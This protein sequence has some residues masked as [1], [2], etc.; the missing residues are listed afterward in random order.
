MER[1]KIENFRLDLAIDALLI[2]SSISLLIFSIFSIQGNILQLIFSLLA[3]SLL[4]GYA[5][6]TIFGLSAH[7]S[8]LEK[9]VISFVLSYAFTGF[10]TLI[11]LNL[12]E[13]V[14]VI[15]ILSS[16]ILLGL[17]S[18][19]RHRKQKTFQPPKSLAQNIDSLAIIM[20]LIFLA[21]S[22]YIL[23]PGFTLLLGTDAS[24]HYSLSV[25]LNRTPE[26]YI[27]STYLASHLHESMFIALSNSSA[28]AVQSALVSLN[29]MLPLAFYIMAK[30]YLEKIDARL[31]SV[32][33]LFWV[34][35]TNGY[36]GFSW[37]YLAFLKL[38]SIGQSQIQILSVTADKTYNGTIYGILGLW[39]IPGVVSVIAFLVAF[40]LLRKKDIPATKCIL[41]FSII[42]AMLFLTH[43]TEAVI[44]AL[45]IAAY[46]AF[47]KNPR[48]KIDSALKGSLIGF[49]L[50]A[51]IYYF[52]SQFTSRF[53]LTI[54]LLTSI[55]LP[56]VIL[57]CSL[58]I[59]R[60]R[61]KINF[62]IYY[63]KKIV[64][65]SP[66]TFVIILI[67]VYFLGLFSWFSF[68]D[69]FHTSQVDATGVVPWF[70]YP[71]MLGITGILSILTLYYITENAGNYKSLRIFIAF[72]IFAFVAGTL[73]SIL[74]L[75][76]FNVN[77]WEKRFIW[78]IKIP[79]ALLAPISVILL[80]DRLRNRFS[81]PSLKIVASIALIGIICLYGVSTTYLNVEYWNNYTENNENHPSSTELAALEAYKNILDND[82]TAWSATV[83]SKSASATVFAAPADMIV[84]RQLLYDV[85]SPEMVLTQLYRNPIYSHPYLYLDNRDYIYL[86]TFS[87]QFLSQYLVPTLPIVFSNS[88]VNI[89]NVSQLSFPQP[90][91]GNVLIAPFDK[92]VVN[93]QSSLITFYALSYGGYDYTVLYDIDH[94]ALSFDS[95]V[96]SFDPPKEKSIVNVFQDGFN[97]TLNSWTAVKGNWNIRDSQLIGSEDGTTGEGILLSSTIAENFTSTVKVTP[98]T[99]NNTIANYVSLIY[100]WTDP[101]NYRLADLFFN[102]DGYIYLFFR[103]FVNGVETD[104]P[105]WPGTKTD[106]KWEFNNEYN[107]KLTVNGVLNEL[108]VNNSTISQS[109]FENIKGKIGLHYYRFSIV[110]FDDFLVSYSQSISS[111]STSDYLNYLNSGGK[112]VVMNTNGDGYFSKE[113]FSDSNATIIAQ[114]LTRNGTRITLP[115]EFSVPL[116]TPKDGGLTTISQYSG[117]GYESPYIVQKNYENGG[118]LY[119]VNVYP[120]VQAIQNSD[121]QSDFYGLLSRLLD[122]INLVKVESSNPLSSFN[123]YVKQISLK[124]DVQIETN[125]VLLPPELSLKQIEVK[126]GN[127]SNIFYN[128][129]NIEVNDYSKVV[130]QSD[131]AII[132]DGNGFY[133]EPQFNSTFSIEPSANTFN[134]KITT[135]NKTYNINNVDYLLLTPISNLQMQVRTPTVSAFEIKFTEFYLQKYPK[136]TTQIYGQDLDVNGFTTFSIMISDNY[137]AIS[138]L[139]LGSFSP[140]SSQATQYEIWS[141]LPTAMFWALLLLPLFIVAFFLFNFKESKGNNQKNQT[142][143]L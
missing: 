115:S 70:M 136:L 111:R 100:S 31:P 71:L 139:T 69:S 16:Y 62:N 103:N 21:L 119:Y 114:Y 141:T 49:T 42:I 85:D 35:F 55:A 26:L 30:Q 84:L 105:K 8:K 98:L 13:N 117:F 130:I 66:K 32:A 51:I 81:I 67:F 121:N 17:I 9:V 79:L 65:S 116:F 48:V 24:R 104:S 56:V 90:E 113:L 73:V 74:N 45:F 112:L 94:N 137:Q 57:T 92:S 107:I 76:F 127:I 143:K 75:Y 18:T 50:S 54:P 7:F 64:K 123:G 96:L 15:Y 120:L 22:L 129:R 99:G 109:N 133:A 89:Y 80:I 88:E 37:I 41:L 140:I 27:G 61:L 83:T 110:S 134:L 72:L 40:L 93:E 118:E 95:E 38:S 82:P 46:G 36:G 142:G 23:Y 91:S 68:V 29:L 108:S 58:I 60:L 135:D 39:Y 4:S 101:K 63:L 6:L 124:H 5:L 125:S 52:F 25:V 86:K 12:S 126:S 34:F 53:I 131:N 87:N 132:Q 59:R 19:L 20:A 77:Y 11:F 44:F 10:V 102:S 2:L 1:F 3:T 28:M 14:R 138:N 106:L 47:S 97:Q 78:F 122:G 43:V 33:T 128:V